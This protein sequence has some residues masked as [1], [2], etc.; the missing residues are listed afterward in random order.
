MAFFPVNLEEFN[1]YGIPAPLTNLGK[2]GHEFLV[3]EDG[4]VFTFSVLENV[5]SVEREYSAFQL[6]LYSSGSQILRESLPASR[7][8]A[9]H[10]LS[11]L[12]QV[13]EMLVGFL[14]AQQGT[15]LF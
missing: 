11:Q 12:D 2:A 3:R 4:A 10:G 6:A 8:T 7:G 1:T 15:P 9:F 14:G 5:I 13:P